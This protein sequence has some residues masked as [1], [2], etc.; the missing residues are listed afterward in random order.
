MSH[1]VNYFHIENK[2]ETEESISFDATKDSQN[3]NAAKHHYRVELANTEETDEFDCPSHSAQKNL[4]I[5]YT[6]EE[7]EPEGEPLN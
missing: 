7:D 2:S 3:H 4:T 5:T 1:V 6:N